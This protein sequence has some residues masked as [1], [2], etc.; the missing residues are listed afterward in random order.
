MTSSSWL[1]NDNCTDQLFKKKKVIDIL[2]MASDKPEPKA[3]TSSSTD[4]PQKAAKT[5]SHETAGAGIRGI[6]TTSLFRAVNFE[7]YAKP[8]RQFVLSSVYYYSI[9]K[10]VRLKKINCMIHV[11]KLLCMFVLDLAKSKLL[12][13]FIFFACLF[14]FFFSSVFFFFFLNK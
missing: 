3:S 12:F 13:Y 2:R 14:F 7:L 11:S 9:L 5:S 10:S 1:N 8:V 4:A 6:R